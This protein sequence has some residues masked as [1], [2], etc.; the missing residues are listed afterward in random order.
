MFFFS[1]SQT[2]LFTQPINNNHLGNVTQNLR[3][4]NMP[5][6]SPILQQQMNSGIMTTPTSIVRV[7]QPQNMQQTHHIAQNQGQFQSQTLW[8]NAMP[9]SPQHQFTLQK[10]PQQSPIVHYATVKNGQRIEH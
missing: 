2:L 4:T 1:F 8:T 5:N 10:A 9:Q 3:Q 6:G 7:N